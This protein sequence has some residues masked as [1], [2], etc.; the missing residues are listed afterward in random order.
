M[1]AYNTPGREQASNGIRLQLAA[2]SGHQGTI[3]VE[4]VFEMRLQAE[5][6]PGP[7]ACETVQGSAAIDG[8]VILSAQDS[9]SLAVAA[10]SRP[11][12]LSQ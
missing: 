6:A 12:A 1:L 5:P 2:I 11:G 4:Q 8:I 7:L 9:Q 10:L 3:H